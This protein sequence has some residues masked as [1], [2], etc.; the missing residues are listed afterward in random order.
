MIVFLLPLATS[1]ALRAPPF[2]CTTI[3]CSA[4]VPQVVASADPLADLF[5]DLLTT[6]SAVA[7]QKAGTGRGLVATR[8]V[9]AGDV[10]LTVPKKFLLTAHRSG[11]IGGLQ[12]QTDLLWD[13][14]G[15]LRQEVGEELFSRARRGMCASRSRCLTR[16]RAQAVHFG[17]AIGVC[18]RRRHG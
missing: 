10:L 17:T 18:C 2:S 6:Q 14:V 7:L 12:G 1:G 4:R 13:A 16:A 11:V 3:P 5:G 15:D 9:G 8:D